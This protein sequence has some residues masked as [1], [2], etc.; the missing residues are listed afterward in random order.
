MSDLFALQNEITSR[1][2]IALN[3]ELV[4]AETARPAEKPDALDYILRARAA[5]YKPRSLETYAD[6][7]SLFERALALDP[8]SVEAQS[9]LAMNLVGRVLDFG[10]RSDSGDL[11]RAEDL[12]AKA[13]AGSPRSAL[14]HLA[15]AN[16]L[17]AQRRCKEAI[18][19]Y[20]TVLAA[21]H[22]SVSALADNGRCK[23]YAGPIE[24]GIAAQEQ[25]I[26][27][28]PRDPYTWIWFFRI[29][30]GHLLQSRID[31]AIL[32]LEKARNANPAPSWI[33][34]YLAS[35]YALKGESERAA[36]ELADARKLGGEGSWQSI[37]P[38]RASTRYETAD[39]RALAEATY[40]AGLRKAGV[41]EE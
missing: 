41:P 35:A 22:N 14:A 13:L 27:L 9:L 6:A 29:G 39:I 25:A 33:P 26:W 7:I 3:L 11:K 1:I 28:S 10:S 20:E 21:N 18:P 36:A 37:A 19:E 24:E 2:A 4:A 38:V 34:A 5:M 17:R 23:I 30:E 31:H 32:W 12:A 16:V 8:G 40:W 15:K